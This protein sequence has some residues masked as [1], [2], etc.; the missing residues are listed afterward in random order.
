MVSLIRKE[1]SSWTSVAVSNGEPT[2]RIHMN[3][4]QQMK[5]YWACLKSNN[6]CLTCLRRK[7]EYALSCGHSMCEI[8][9]QIFGDKRSVAECQFHLQACVL[10]AVGNIT[11]TL[12]PPT[13]GIRL[14]TIDG[15][16]IRGVVPLEFLGMLQKVIGVDCPLQDFF[17]LAFGTSSG[18]SIPSCKS[19]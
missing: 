16:G 4:L 11:V 7:P 6:T 2:A 10:C 5:S 13:A 17:D 8:C 18:K 14:L 9:I 19:S 15:G 3:N 12:K 1:F